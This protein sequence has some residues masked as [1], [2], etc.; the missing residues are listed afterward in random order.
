M[1]NVVGAAESA[2]HAGKRAGFLLAYADAPNLPIAQHIQS[3][4]W[5][6]FVQHVRPRVIGIGALSYQALI[7]LAITAT[8]MDSVW[9]EL[10]AWVVRKIANVSQSRSKS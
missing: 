2:R 9:P 6:N 7:Q 3:G 4:A 8:P 5:Q 10:E 1:R